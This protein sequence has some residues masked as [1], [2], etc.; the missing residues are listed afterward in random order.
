LG[1]NRATNTLYVGNTLDGSLSMVDAV[2]GMSKGVI[3]LAVPVRNDKGEE[4]LAHTRKV[5]VDEQHNRVFVTSPGQP[6]L[7]WIVDGATNT[8]THTITSDGIWTAGAAYDAQANR[9]YVSQG[10]IH[11]ILVID[12]EARQVVNSFS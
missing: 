3:Q 9:L 5:V 6:G 2:S 7:V 12:P 11:E 4:S 10:G 8:L 1:L